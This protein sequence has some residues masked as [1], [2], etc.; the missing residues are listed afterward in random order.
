MSERQF[1]PFEA[2]ASLKRHGSF[3]SFPLPSLVNT[4]GET[5]LFNFCGENSQTMCG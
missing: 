1:A 2:H 4:S 3:I 5:H